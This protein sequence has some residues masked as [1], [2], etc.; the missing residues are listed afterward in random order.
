[1]SGEP[2]SIITS[3]IDYCNSFLIG[4]PNSALDSLGS[5]ECSTGIFN[6]HKLVEIHCIHAQFAV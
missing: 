4:L 5:S 1:M 3:L 6:S 2:T